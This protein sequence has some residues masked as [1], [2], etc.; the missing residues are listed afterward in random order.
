LQV[1]DNLVDV[2][3]VLF[4]FRRLSKHFFLLALWNPL[5]LFSLANIAGYGLQWVPDIMSHHACRSANSG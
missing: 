4:N 1:S 2:I 3:D 5:I